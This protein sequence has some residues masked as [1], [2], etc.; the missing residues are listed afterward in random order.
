[1]CLI[2]V[3]LSAGKP[4]ISAVTTVPQ[5]GGET[6]PAQEF[7]KALKANRTKC[8]FNRTG[9][10]WNPSRMDAG[11]GQFNVGSETAGMETAGS[12]TA[13]M[14]TAGMET[15]GSETAGL[16]TAGLETAGSETSES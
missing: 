9:L 6:L 5:Q 8:S 11:M 1:M 13:G 12:E 14:E 10:S 4:V 3:I 2:S 16:E 7:P 15:A